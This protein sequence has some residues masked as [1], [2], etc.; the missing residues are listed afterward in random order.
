MKSVIVD[1]PISWKRNSN[2]KYSGNSLSTLG[3]QNKN[4]GATSQA[5]FGLRLRHRLS[6]SVSPFPP[7]IQK[8]FSIICG[9]FAHISSLRSQKQNFSDYTV[10]QRHLWNYCT[11]TTTLQYTCCTQTDNH[12]TSRTKTNRRTE[13]EQYTR[14]N[15]ATARL[16]T[17][18]KPADT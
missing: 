18:V 9:V 8:C 10:H 15:A 4:I 1:L 5:G 17:L 14:S 13:R 11:Y 16:L 7:Q 2:R 6:F 12:F 3:A